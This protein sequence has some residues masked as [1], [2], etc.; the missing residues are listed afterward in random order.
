M[1]RLLMLGFL[2]A[3]FIRADGGAMSDSERSYLIEQLEQS[4]KAMLASIDGLTEAQW[5]F[6]P[7]PNVWSVQE[8]AEHIVLA[9]SYIFQGS[10]Q[11]LK[12]PA[13]ARPE[14]SN[15]EVDH[16]IVSRV[17]DR[18]QKATAPEPLVP[19]RKFA[20][21]E[22]AAKAFVAARDKTIAYVKSTQDDLRTHVGPGP[23][24]PM[25]AYQFLL[26][27]ASHS[28]RH[29]AQIREVES[30]SGYPKAS[31]APGL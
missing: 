14:R 11:V 19:G 13:V 22:E 6:K 26:L 25:D 2:A 16:V 10:Q 24:G 31:A 7:A 8:C 3:Q 5:K 23:A 15:S 20:T 21:P 30:N 18:S 27:L 28:A 1:R 4:K 9:E 17:Q 12:T 29:T